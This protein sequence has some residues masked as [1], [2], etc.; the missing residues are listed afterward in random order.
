MKTNLF[1]VL[2]VG[3]T[4]AISAPTFA[5]PAS[6]DAPEWENQAIFG[7]NKEPRRATALPFPNRNAALQSLKVPMGSDP[8][9]PFQISLNGQWRFHWSP[10]P[11]SRPQN[12]YQPQFNVA[13]W[14]E[15]KVPMSWQMAGYGVPLYTNVTYPFKVDP[16]RVM[17]TPPSNYTNFSQRNPVG[18]YRR[19][20]TLPANWRNR[21]VFVQFDGVDSAFYLWINGQKVGYSQDSRTPATFNISKYLQPGQN[22]IAA[23]VY[24][25]SD[26]AYLEDQDM[27]RLSGIFRDV[28]LWSSADTQIRDFFAHAD[29]DSTYTHGAFSLDVN[30]KNHDKTAANG[31]VRAEL[32]DANG[33]VVL[34]GTRPLKAVTD[35]TTVNFA[36]TVPNV[37]QWSAEKP[38]LYSLVLTLMDANGKTV[39]A[40]GAR[41]GFRKV[42]IKD[43]K[44]QI[45]GRPIY[46]K[47]TDR[48]DID[49]VLGHTVSQASMIQ[50]IRLMKQHNINAVRTSHYPN[51]PRWYRLC[52]EMGMYLVDETNLECH[53]MQS[54][55]NDPSWEA[56]YVDRGRNMIERDKNHPSVIIWSLGNE[57]GFGVNHVAMYNWFKQ[58]D[59]SRPTQYEAAGE[60]P[61]T[62]IVAPM[63]PSIGGIAN[64][65][66]KNPTRPLIM[67]EYAHS[68]GNSVGNLQDYWDII[69]SNPSLQGGFIW[70]WVDQGL[71]KA[72]PTMRRATDSSVAK[73]TAIITGKY[74]PGQGV[75]G[76]VALDNS[77]GLDLT[78]PLTLEAEA[79][80]KAPSGFNPLISKGDHQ[81]LLRLGNGGTDKVISFV[82]HQDGWKSLNV[83]DDKLKANGWNRITGVYDGA[84]MI[85]YANGEEVGRQAF[86]GKIDSSA[87]PVNIGRDSENTDRV[88]QSAIRHARIYNRAL[89]AGEILANNRPTNGLVL[90]M[91][92][93]RS[94]IVPSKPGA[95]K[96]FFAYGGDFG[97]TPNDG[98]FCINGLVGPN[99]IPNPQLAEV[100]KVYQN[101]KVTPVDLATGRVKIQNKYVFTNLSDFKASWVLR[102]DGKPIQNGTIN[103]VNIAPLS[104]REITLPLKN[105]NVNGERM[106]TIA[107]DLPT[108]T[109]WAPANHRV[110]WDQ[111]ALEN[112][113]P[114]AINRVMPAAQ[115]T[116]T[117]S[118]YQIKGENFTATVNRADG[119][120]NS[121]V[122]NGTEILAQPLV[123]EFWKALTDNS[124][125]TGIANIE[126]AWRNAGT[127]RQIVN[128]AAE[129]QNQSVD[130]TSKMKLSVGDSDYTLSYNF[131]GD[132]KITVKASY[133]PGTGEIPTIPRFGMTTA[134]KPDFDR[135]A[136]YGRGPQETYWD[137]KTGG[138]I[139]LYQMNLNEFTHDYV[140]P[141]DNANRSDVRNF[142]ISNA[143]GIGVKITGTQPLNFAL[144]P[145]SLADL[146][147][148]RHPF[149]LPRRPFNTLHIDAQLEGVGGNDS[150]SRGGQPL[151]KYRIKGNEPHEY[152][153]TIQPLRVR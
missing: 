66:K 93:T 145:Y 55:S 80:G 14:K 100:K 24:R 26:G 84:N 11:A 141:Q 40:T 54:I 58:R 118:A 125:R 117:A 2:A 128:V 50:D 144:W 153:F 17:G 74:L 124:R 3:L 5:A 99:R 76:A 12:F 119:A 68:M 57:A 72:V 127:N 37:A 36:G 49:P 107:F 65:A 48:H 94:E 63:Y 42:E 64:Y 122:F 18:S 51:D 114:S 28:N 134:L 75:T 69:E 20:F 147:R 39:E 97:D 60:R 29:L 123:P 150:W 92:L 102:E 106:L 78:G 138:E 120:L 89:S 79:W 101:I 8:S 130:V 90:D 88:S 7:I 38:N 21:Q 98:N 27:W 30:V 62:D 152:S 31:S 151:E 53:G 82:L 23:E 44:L 4:A 131:A 32:L 104:S 35:E 33:R 111:F 81:Y 149:E 105:T 47:G 113:L 103:N 43:G 135:I 16:P 95:P 19:N 52:D 146:E 96:T 41:I 109:S 112:P 129:Q 140:Q 59:P 70:D 121:L 86:T 71:I 56:A 115:L 136:W 132:G 15:I 73:H 143:Q 9:T 148:A 10:D 77:V 13:N 67:C 139:G 137:R 22:T 6:P 83:P 1:S 116:E 34:Q 91:D 110:A 25:Y 133:Q 45:N 46:I 126:S 61:Q 85:V 142:T 87:F 108:A